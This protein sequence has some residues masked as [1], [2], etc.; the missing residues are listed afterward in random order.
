[1]PFM[2]N[3]FDTYALRKYRINSVKELNPYIFGQDILWTVLSDH[4]PN[5]IA[6][7]PCGLQLV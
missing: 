4:F 7:S 6:N 1:M 5:H 2:C 3:G